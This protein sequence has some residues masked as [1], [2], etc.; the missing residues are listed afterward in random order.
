MRPYFALRVT[1]NGAGMT[2]EIRAGIFEPS[3]TTK[4]PT[5]GTG[6]GLPAVYGIVSESY[7][8]IEVGTEL[9]KGTTFSIFLPLAAS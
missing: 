4:A 8:R 5:K 3:F 2:P 6:L 9:G 1:D 7:G